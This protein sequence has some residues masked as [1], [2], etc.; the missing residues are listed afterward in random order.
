MALLAWLWL[1]SPFA[2]IAP[3]SRDPELQ[4]LV[5]VHYPRCRAAGWTGVLMMCLGA[6]L[7]PALLGTLMFWVGTPLAGLTVWLVGDDGDGGDESD[8]PPVDWDEFE[9]SFW[10]HVR[11]HARTPRRPRAPSAR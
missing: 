10:V 1:A 9:R 7:M 5:A 4:R 6:A 3:I 8:V 11:R 2:V